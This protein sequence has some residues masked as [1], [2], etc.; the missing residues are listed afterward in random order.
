MKKKL[1]IAYFI[2]CI[3]IDVLAFLFAVLLL[4]VD[5]QSGD[6]SARSFFIGLVT[7]PV[8]WFIISVISLK[9][10][11]NEKKK[12]VAVSI[13]LKLFALL[14]VMGISYFFIENGIYAAILFIFN[15]VFQ[16]TKQNGKALVTI[17]LRKGIVDIPLMIALNLV[18]PIYGVVMSQP[19]VDVIGTIVG[20]ILYI[21]YMRKEKKK[22]VKCIGC[23]NAKTC[24]MAQKQ[25]C[26]GIVRKGFADFAGKHTKWVA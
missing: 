12:T 18:I 21:G 19:I 22:G 2:F 11:L 20:L 23:P 3:V 5:T 8:M 4:I 6:D 1:S 7:V 10:C 14:T 26:N 17:V 24:S 13:N 25:K 15:T 9:L 16:G